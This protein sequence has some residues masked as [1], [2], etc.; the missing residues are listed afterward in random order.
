M[1][2]G[3]ES[4]RPRWQA[5]PGPIR[6]RLR[7][8]A[9]RRCTRARVNAV[10]MISFLSQ[11]TLKRRRHHGPNCDGGP[12]NLLTAKFRRRHRNGRSTAM[13]TRS[14]GEPTTIVRE[15]TPT[16]RIHRY[17]SIAASSAP[18][19]SATL[20]L[21]ARRVRRHANAPSMRLGES[22]ELA[23]R[24]ARRSL[25]GRVETKCHAGLGV[26]VCVCT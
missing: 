16:S 23:T 12:R 18:P 2:D 21:L 6:L 25:H 19:S 26:C 1:Y 4:A 15:V 24:G 8:A 14:W 9:P 11:A 13:V 10:L 22:R 20:A 17:S 5:R 7:W 3:Q